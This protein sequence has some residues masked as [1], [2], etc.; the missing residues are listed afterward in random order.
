MRT[1][2][3]AS[4]PSAP[5]A[6]ASQMPDTPNTSPDAVSPLRRRG[7]LLSPVR[8]FSNRRCGSA[9][10]V[11]RLSALGRLTAVP[12]AQ[13]GSPHPQSAP[14]ASRQLSKSQTQHVWRR[15]A[16]C[17]THPP[18]RMED[19]AVT[20][21]LVLGGPTPRLRFLFPGSSPGQALPRALG[22]GFL[23]TPSRDDALA[24]LLAFGSANT[25]RGD[26]HPARSVSCLAHTSKLTRP[27]SR[28]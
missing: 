1:P 7:R 24:L 11:P 17:I 28:A 22:L 21:P 25:W 4:S 13:A 5:A 2:T 14:T 18:G 15:V 19:F 9:S 6:S 20:C 8:A 27:N 26:S 23:Q 3:G 16:G 10:L 12:A